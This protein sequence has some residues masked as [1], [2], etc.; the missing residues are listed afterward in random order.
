MNKNIQV[1][2]NMFVLPIDMDTSLGKS[3][4]ERGL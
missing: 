3:R 2:E 4:C 1:G